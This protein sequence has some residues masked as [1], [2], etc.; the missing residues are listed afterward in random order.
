MSRP[1]IK[2]PS[3]SVVSTALAAITS[4]AS[5]GAAG[6][7]IGSVESV[8]Q[9]ITDITNAAAAR[10]ITPD[11]EASALLG[12]IPDVPVQL[13]AALAPLQAAFATRAAQL[14]RNVNELFP[15]DPAHSDPQLYTIYTQELAADAAAASTVTTIQNDI[16]R[17]V[18]SGAISVTS[19]LADM[20]AAGAS[21]SVRF[22]LLLAVAKADP[23]DQLNAV[24]AAFTTIVGQSFGPSNSLFFSAPAAHAG[25]DFA[26]IINSN[27]S[28]T[29]SAAIA[30]IESFETAQNGSVDSGLDYLQ[31]LFGTEEGNL[32]V[33]VSSG[34]DPN[35]NADASLFDTL[36]SGVDTIGTEEQL[37][38]ADGSLAGQLAEN[39]AQ[40]TVNHDPTA[41]TVSQEHDPSIDDKAAAEICRSVPIRCGYG[42]V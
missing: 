20:S 36:E 21:T 4:L 8:S 16:V 31:T 40:G 10:T 34:T 32:A 22:A 23:A 14:P 42:R 11:Q 2:I 7:L 41:L 12:L 24:G 35:A 17:L 6:T 9:G 38:V 28:M 19:L 33:A 18:T 13:N 29:V 39:V 25:V 1:V 5:A 30:D 26:K 15:G 37:R 3:G 27:G